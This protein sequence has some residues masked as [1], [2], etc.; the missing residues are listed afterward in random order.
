VAI[1]GE[2]TGA[3]RTQQGKNEMSDA[4]PSTEPVPFET[5]VRFAIGGPAEPAQAV[6]ASEEEFDQ[7]FDGHPPAHAG[8]DFQR[9]LVIAVAMGT[10]SS[11]GH[12]IEI[13][14]IDRITG[15]SS[16]GELVVH[17][18]E[19]H[20]DPRSFVSHIMTAPYHVVRCEAGAGGP[21]RFVR[22]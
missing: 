13:T 11:G 7:F 12:S 3:F 8:I 10:Q 19:Q 21:V 17:Y 5:V 2:A 15:G 18:Q 22:E 6:I 1:P 4:S 14:A 9:S 16:P 20:P